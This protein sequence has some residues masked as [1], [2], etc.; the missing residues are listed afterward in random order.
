MKK[1]IRSAQRGQSLVEFALILPAFLL[2]AVVVFDLGRA[3]YYSSTLHNAAREAAR[4][5]IVHPGDEPGMKEAAIDYAIGLGLT[6]TD[7]NVSLIGITGTSNYPPPHVTIFINYDFY[8]ATP[9]V[10]SF[11]PNTCVDGNKCIV[12]KGEATMKLEAL[13]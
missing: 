4:F 9:I 10:A 5:G 13:P 3:V 11:L 12:L 2:M 1:L 6:D 8:P 7:I